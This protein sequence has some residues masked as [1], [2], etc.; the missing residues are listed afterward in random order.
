[1]GRQS[2]GQIEAG[3]MKFKVLGDSSSDFKFKIKSVV[4]SLLKCSTVMILNNMILS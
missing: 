4:F 3:G 2:H 1:M